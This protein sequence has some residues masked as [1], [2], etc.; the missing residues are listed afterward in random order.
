[1][2]EE[3][4]LLKVAARKCEV[5]KLSL[6]EANDFLHAH[7]R[8]GATSS[9]C[10]ITS[11]GLYHGAV[12]VGVAQFCA[13]RT[14]A[15]RRRYST[16]LLRM[17]FHRSYRVRGG[18][19]KLVAH[20]KR[21]Y[22]PADIF[23]YQDATGEV[24][25]VYE[26]CGF[27][28]VRQGGVKK[29]LVAPGRTLKTASR[30]EAFGFAYA[31]RFGPDR[32]LG[33]K[34]GEVY[35]ADG[36]RKTNPELFLEEL[37]WHV[38]TTPADRV[39]EW[40]NPAVSFYTYKITA[41]DSDKYYI[42]VR[43]LPVGNAT[44]EACLQDPYMG[45]GAKHFQHW[46]AK[47]ASTLEKEILGVFRS[48][49]EAFAH[50]KAAVGEAWRTDPLC[51]NSVAGG[52]ASSKTYPQ[53]QKLPLRECPTHGRV[54]H[55]G[56]T[57]MSCA[58]EGNF[59]RQE[60]EVHGVSSHIGSLCQKC[61]AQAFTTQ[62]ACPTHGLATHQHGQC[63]QCRRAS[64]TS[65]KECPTHG[66]TRHRGD[67]CPSCTL[68]AMDSVAHCAVHGLTAHRGGSCFRC[69]AERAVAVRECP[70]H[71]EVKH[72]GEKCY[73]C[74][75]A[76]HRAEAGLCSIHGPTLFKW[77]KCTKCST[78]N[79]STQEECALHGVVTFQW[80]KCTR[81]RALASA[82]RRGKHEAAVEICPLCREAAKDSSGVTPEG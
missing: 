39:Y 3:V 73:Q 40:F 26:H 52:F 79:R 48:R 28:L 77:G 75:G 69:S 33:T 38:E 29:Y 45:S 49:A 10:K 37:G 42:G 43:K 62:E 36:R 55:A 11:L 2:L 21:L 7:H 13:P 61:Y 78:K 44:V 68:E 47:H 20:Y 54:A 35:R 24:T 74:I 12:L 18:A 4:A 70:V 57:C 80:G 6:E 1:M 8:Q 72:L 71:G 9:S 53:N 50:E 32:I 14:A 19:S 82:H 34:L 22:K 81:C 25:E 17:A 27:T 51:L 56:P 67:K 31:V 58:T 59:T 23:T 66:L 30:R 41:S 76:F 63:L 16:E 60:C 5:Q 65:L 64:E 15:M 46:R